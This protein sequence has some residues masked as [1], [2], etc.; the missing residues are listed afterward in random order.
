MVDICS[1]NKIVDLAALDYVITI[2]LCA[3][4]WVYLEIVHLL[5]VYA[6]QARATFYNIV[7]AAIYWGRTRCFS[8]AKPFCLIVVFAGAKPAWA[9]G[10]QLT[11]AVAALINLIKT[12]TKALASVCGK[13]GFYRCRKRNLV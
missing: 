7:I 12:E 13:Q 10:S 6:A 9:I 11:N 8:K 1:V 3:N 2:A 5:K 4:R